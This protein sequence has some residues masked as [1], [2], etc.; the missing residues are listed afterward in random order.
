[1]HRSE[2]REPP[3]ELLDPTHALYAAAAQ[4]GLG[5][6]WTP[7][8]RAR[9]LLAGQRGASINVTVTLTAPPTVAV[10]VGDELVATICDVPAPGGMFQ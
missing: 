2:V 1:M 5:H 4:V 9:V 8:E 7:E 10:H 3:A 6:V